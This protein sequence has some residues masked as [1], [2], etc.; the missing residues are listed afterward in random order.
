MPQR[1]WD[2]ANLDRDQSIL[3]RDQAKFERDQAILERDQRILDRDLLKTDDRDL[4]EQEQKLQESVVNSD[5]IK[6]EIERLQWRLQE[7]ASDKERKMKT[8]TEPLTTRP[9]PE[10]MMEEDVSPRSSG[11]FNLDRVAQEHMIAG[12]GTW[13][14]SELVPSLRN[15]DSGRIR[16]FMDI[17]LPGLTPS[18]TSGRQSGAGT[19]RLKELQKRL[20]ARIPESPAR[21]AASITWREYPE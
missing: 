4:L 9:I 6:S 12:L 2:E 8:A 5:Q 15:L 14:S 11:R 1:E 20:Q 18:S 17:T 10:S 13:M 21:R 7:V 16:P 19:S 3:V